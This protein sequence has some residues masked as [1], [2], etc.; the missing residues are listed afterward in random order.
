MMRKKT[1]ML[2]LICIL[3]SAADILAFPVFDGANLAQNILG[4]ANQYKVLEKEAM[5]V[6][7][8]LR[9]IQNQAQQIIKAKNQLKLM[10]RNLERLA[11]VLK[12]PDYKSIQKVQMLVDGVKGLPYTIQNIKTSFSKVYPSYQG[13]VDT[14]TLSEDYKKWVEHTE[15]SIIDAISVQGSVVDI[16]SDKNDLL[17][18]I[19]ASR[20]AKGNLEAT[21]AQ[22][23]IDGLIVKQIMRLQQMVAASERSNSVMMAEKQKREQAM[24]A[25]H[26]ELMKGWDKKSTAVPMTDFP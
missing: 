23:E 22:T 9:Q 5:Q 20:K 14:K 8:N 7:Q 11:I 1:F 15:A 25:R 2:S 12:D 24:I 17:T 4:V 19:R 10:H 13:A 26:K 18:A 21:Q 3:I 6:S 16:R